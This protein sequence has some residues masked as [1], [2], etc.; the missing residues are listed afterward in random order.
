MSGVLNFAQ[1]DLVT[2][3]IY[4]FLL[5][6]GGGGAVALVGLSPALLGAGVVVALAVGAA[7]ALTV[8]RAAVAPFVSRGS[9]V[10]WVAATAAAGL[11]LRALA[12]V[13]FQAES[14]TVPEVIPIRSLLGFESVSLPGGAVLQIR[15][16]VVLATGLLVALAFDRWLARSRTGRG[17]QA[18]TQDSDAAR[19]CGLSPAG[20]QLRAWA[21]A[22][23]L[24]VVA[25]LLIAPTRPL[26]LEFGVVLGLKG[27]AAAVLGRLGSARGTIVAGLAIGVGESLLTTL[28]LPGV[29][30]G[31]V[32]LP[33]MGPLPGLQD[34]AALVVLVLALGVAP[35][36]LGLRSG[37]VD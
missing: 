5:V 21:L 24:A 26:T 7:V 36:L 31:P 32:S 30:I 10:G 19:L 4:T 6:V 28:S 15:A 12:G 3:G 16:V 34:I 8:D 11:F 2:A 33:A 14:Y 1:G 18:T 23:A 29:G 27:T 35:R 37:D 22:G 20:L 9:V 17:M 25:G 13:R